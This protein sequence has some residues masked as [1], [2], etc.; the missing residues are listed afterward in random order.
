MYACKLARDYK[1]KDMKH[2]LA[3]KYPKCQLMNL[4]LLLTV[5]TS[6]NVQ[7]HLSTYRKLRVSFYLY[8]YPAM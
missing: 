4:K 7:L 2:I 3:S 5:I 6:V 8:Y 1:S